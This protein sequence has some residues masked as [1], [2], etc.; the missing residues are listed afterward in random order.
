VEDIF[1]RAESL[2]I[3]IDPN[4]KRLIELQTLLQDA[5]G[6]RESL[7]E[8]GESTKATDGLIDQIR[9]EIRAETGKIR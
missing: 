3:K 9:T 8:A 5:G 6:W 7:E 1:G 4:Q 2:G